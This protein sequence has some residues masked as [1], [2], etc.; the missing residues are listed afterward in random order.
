[1]PAGTVEYQHGVRA[2]CD[3]ACDLVKME[4][5]RF[6]VREWQSE[7]RALSFGWANGS[8]QIGALV[9]LVRGLARACST[10]RPLPNEPVLL[11]NPGFVLEPDFKWGS[12]WQ[13]RQVNV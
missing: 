8:E 12:C 11:T 10:A 6:G 9:A 4:L 1:V 2:D 3:V 13:V 5:H 7:R